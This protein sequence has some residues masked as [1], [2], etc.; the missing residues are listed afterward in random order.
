MVATT[1][2]LIGGVALVVFDISRGAA[3]FLL[4]GFLVEVG[5]WLMRVRGKPGHNLPI[6]DPDRF[7][8]QYPWWLWASMVFLTF[9]AIAG[10]LTFFLLQSYWGLAQGLFM[11]LLVT[12]GATGWAVHRL[13]PRTVER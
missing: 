4:L 5:I 7:V 6:P 10:F 1:G 8:G 9:M 2:L 3:S 12:A 11:T 13:R